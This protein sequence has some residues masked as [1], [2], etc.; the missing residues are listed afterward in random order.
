MYDIL[1]IGGGPAGL[2]SAI[3]GVRGGLKV[4]FM[5]KMSY[6]GQIIN[7]PEVENYPGTGKV[8]GFELA[9]NMYQQAKGLGA[10]MV[11]GEAVGIK[12]AEDADGK[13]IFIV[14]TRD[15]SQPMPE[16]PA[17]SDDIP[18]G[19]SYEARAVILATGLKQ[20]PAGLDREEQMTGAGVSYC[21]T[22]DGGFFRGKDVAILGGGNTAL[23]DAEYM[24]G[25]ANK[26][27][28]VHRRDEFRG[29]EVTV[30]R[31]RSKDNVEFVL[32]SVPVEI[33]GSPTVDGLKVKSVKTDEERDLKVD[34]IFVAYGHIPVNGLFKDLAT[35]D[36]TGFFDSGEDCKTV[37]P[38]IFV[39]GDCRAKTRRQLVTATSDGAIAA[40]NAIE[41]IH[42][43]G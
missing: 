10:E 8:S 2:T 22:C 11:F 15:M 25:L 18:K 9:E 37:T 17:S 28:L 5:E 7:T 43:L 19:Q 20:R 35:L 39:A 41:Y 6:G 4:A 33:L 42:N 23:E 12:R 32:S 13:P 31:L 24:A 14:E 40:M 30:E 38:G 36:D 3:Y 21:A 29:D 16:D 26:V 1:I 34:G 27:Y